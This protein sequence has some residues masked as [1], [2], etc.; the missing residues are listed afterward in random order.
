MDIHTI[1]DTRVA[2]VHTRHQHDTR[3]GWVDARHALIARE[4]VPRNHGWDPFWRFQG[5]KKSDTEWWS[6]GLRWLLGFGRGGFGPWKE[7][8][9]HNTTVREPCMDDYFAGVGMNFR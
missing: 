4:C 9:N 6:A 1:H 5:L 3:D 2:E 7:P 8:T